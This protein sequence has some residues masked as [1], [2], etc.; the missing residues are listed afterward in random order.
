MLCHRYQLPHSCRLSVAPRV[1]P[2][3]KERKYTNRRIPCVAPGGAFAQPER[4]SRLWHLEGRAGIGP[5][6]L[7]WLSHFSPQGPTR[8]PS[9]I[10]AFRCFHPREV[11]PPSRRAYPGF[12]V[13][14]GGYPLGAFPVQSQGEPSPSRSAN[15]GFDL[16]WNR[17]D[18]NRQPPDPK[19]GALPLALLLRLRPLPN[20]AANPAALAD[21]PFGS[22]G[23]KERNPGLQKPLRPARRWRQSSGLN[24]FGPSPLCH[25]SPFSGEVL[26]SLSSCV[27]LP[28]S[29][30]PTVYLPPQVCGHFF[31]P[32]SREIQAVPISP[33]PSDSRP[34]LPLPRQEI[35]RPRCTPAST[36]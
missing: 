34:F 26:I 24:G 32:A 35:L 15:P 25:L 4:Q 22:A 8:E 28:L 27:I 23:E 18:S 16:W 17:P 20:P 3:R 5:D 11:F 2:R 7:L 13:I 33:R 19:S 30:S 36:L 6:F 12:D 14:L 29:I 21:L 1:F 9:H 31:I 10:G